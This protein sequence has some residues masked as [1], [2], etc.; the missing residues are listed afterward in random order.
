MIIGIPREIKQDEYRVAMLPVGA[1]LLIGDGHKIV[2]EKGA[3]LGSGF[4]DVAYAS[5]GA[6]LVDSAEELYAKAEMIVKVKEPQPEEIE[7][8]RPGLVVFCYFHF[9]GSRELTEGCLRKRIAA[10]AYETL[11][12]EQERLPL[13]TPM[14]EVAGKMSIQEGAKCLEKPMMGRGILL[15]GVSGVEPANVLIIGGGVVGSNAARVAAGLGARVTIMD[16]NLD[17]LRYLNET[18]PPNITT[19]YC[20]P[21]AVRRYASKADLIVGAVL[22]PGGKTPVL[23]DRQ[24]LK[25][26]KKGSVLV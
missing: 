17:R 7:W 26:M 11:A 2:F 4:D 18:M 19:V 6:E 23:I 16:I 5:A 14:S 10:V 24:V 25:Q 9:A 1:E 15:G 3:G 13:L 8:L 22:I 12:D 21:H 20:D